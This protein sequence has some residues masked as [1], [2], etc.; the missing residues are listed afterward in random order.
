MWQDN[1]VTYLWSHE[2]R[3]TAE[4]ARGGAIVHILLTQT[5]I[6]DLDVSIQGQHDVVELEVTIHDTVLVK[7][8]QG[9]AH[10]GSVE[11]G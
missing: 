1:R 2:L 6:G 8:L 5:I 9:Q 4:G 3:S 11:S 7:V 10:F